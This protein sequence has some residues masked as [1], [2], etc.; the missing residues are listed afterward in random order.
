[1]NKIISGFTVQSSSSEPSEAEDEEEKYKVENLHAQKQKQIN[2][3]IKKTVLIKSEA[4]VD[5]EL[6]NGGKEKSVEETLKRKCGE[7]LSQEKKLSSLPIKVLLQKKSL[8]AKTIKNEN[9]IAKTHRETCKRVFATVNSVHSPVKQLKISSKETGNISGVKTKLVSENEESELKNEE[10]ESSVKEI[11]KENLS[12]PLTLIKNMSP[13]KKVILLKKKT[14]LAETTKPEILIEN[15]AGG[16]PMKMFASVSSINY[17][18]NDYLSEE[19][20]TVKSTP[21]FTKKISL[22]ASKK[23]EGLISTTEGIQAPVITDETVSSLC[24]DFVR[25]VEVQTDVIENKYT[26]SDIEKVSF[27]I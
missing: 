15:R 1:M 19:I 25:S 4:K 21:P 22:K 20:K 24:Q 16:R 9:L 2:K 6:Q 27:L 3:N 8:L 18:E 14:L 5:S 23:D 7:P 17:P 10:K 26:K 11:V 13:P 12:K